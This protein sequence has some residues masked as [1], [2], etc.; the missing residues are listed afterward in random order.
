MSEII[1]HGR[2]VQSVDVEIDERDFLSLL[3][4]TFQSLFGVN[5]MSN[6]AS[7]VTLYGDN[8]LVRCTD[9]SHHGSPAYDH[10]TISKDP[11]VID[12]YKKF[13]ELHKVYEERLKQ[14]EDERIRYHRMKLEMEKEE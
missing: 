3:E 7:Y 13:V 1:V 11:F 2:R 6:G 4:K 8:R 10:K 5:V 14:L 12:A 9:I